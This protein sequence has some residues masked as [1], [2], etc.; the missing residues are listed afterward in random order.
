MDIVLNRRDVGYTVVSRFEAAFRGFIENT[1][2]ILYSNFQ[3]GIPNGVTNKASE[4]SSLN[5]FNDLSDLLDNIDFPDLTEIVIYNSGF[6]NFFPQSLVQIDTFKELMQDIYMLRCKIAHINGYF[7]SLD[8]DRLLDCCRKIATLLGDNGCEFNSFVNELER[9]PESVVITMPISFAC[10]WQNVF[11]IPQN[12]PVP[13]YEFEGG[14]IGR[15]QDIS[16]ITKLLLGDLHRVVT[17]SGAGGVGKSAL[18]LKVVNN[19]LLSNKYPFEGAIWLS[20]KEDQLTYAGI[21]E[22]EPSLKNYETLL[23]T[24]AE[25][26]GFAF[27]DETSL[28]KKEEDVKTIFELHNRILLIVDNFETVTDQR[29]IDFMLD[30]PQNCKI[31]VT[32]RRGIGQ[33]ERRYELQQLKE[34]EAAYLFRQLARDK[35]LFSLA[36]LDDNIIRTYV[37][38]VACYPLAIKWV[39]GRVSL[40]QDLKTV[41]NEISNTSSDISLF[42]FDKIFNSLSIESKTLLYTLSCFEETPAPGVVKYVSD[43]NGNAFA[44]SIHELILVSLII[45]EQS[46]D[47][48]GEIE[49]RYGLLPLTRGYVRKQLDNDSALKSTIDDR[50]RSVAT[51]VAEAARAKKQYRF[52]LQNLGASTEEEKVAAMLVQT[53]FQK[54]QAGRYDDAVADYKRARDIAQ[55]FSSIY[56][57]WAV[58]ESNEG[59]NSEANRLMQ[60]AANLS[61]G[62]PLIWLT[63]GNMARKENKIDDAFKHLEKAHKLSPDDYVILNALGQVRNRQG[64][65]SIA[66]NL[67]MTA[68]NKESTGSTIRHEIINKSSIADNLGKWA[69]EKEKNRDYQMAEKIYLE[70]LKFANEAYQQDVSDPK[71]IALQKFICFKIGCFYRQRNDFKNALK[72]YSQIISGNPTKYK[73]AKTIL[74]AALSMAEIHYQLSSFDQVVNCLSQSILSLARRND[75]GIYKKMQAILSQI[76]NQA[77]CI[78]GTIIRVNLQKHFL[79][80]ESVTA[81]GNTYLGFKSD[82]VQQPC[83]ISQDMVGKKV[84]FLPSIEQY[85]NEEKRIAKMISFGSDY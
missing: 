17:I 69:Q 47:A 27:D 21:E 85:L 31:L 55:G 28:E 22:L 83:E 26:M 40:G 12:L 56:R 5:N 60:I 54:Y 42:C 13:D 14:F 51:T 58:M 72:Y 2:Q 41:A 1:L 15:E 61:P 84:S 37:N 38:K 81:P 68:L 46:I 62:D 29:I 77:K 35:N 8:L 36:K 63:W 6:P 7:T 70:A 53:A 50:I 66:H 10:E 39:I 59:H 11:T 78:N 23:D 79:I 67:F 71:S 43:L 52:S 33:V 80:V 82:I 45:P 73:E 16:A 64:E 76:N 74:F 49:S 25:V 9:K 65:Y 24:V 20:A 18:A 19:I 3:E 48:R 75:L 30:S 32:S 44:D 34:K 4:R 57:N